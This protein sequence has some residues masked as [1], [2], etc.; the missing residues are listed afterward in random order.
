MPRRQF[1][2][3]EAAEIIMMDLP[4]DDAVDTD[5]EDDSDDDEQEP[6]LFKRDSLPADV[7][8]EDSTEANSEPDVSSD[9]DSDI[10]TPYCVDQNRLWRKLGKDELIEPFDLPQGPIM[11]HFLDC[12]NE[13][14]YCLK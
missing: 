6:S 14:D 7:P 8:D 2:A 5:V 3:I 13:V 4:I 10:S 9:D 12:S 11:D 1:T